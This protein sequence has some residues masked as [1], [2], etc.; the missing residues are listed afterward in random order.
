[1]RVAYATVARRHAIGQTSVMPLGGWGR[2]GGNRGSRNSLPGASECSLLSCRPACL[3]S[4]GWWGK[5]ELS[6]AALF[7]LAHRTRMYTGE[8]DGELARALLKLL[9]ERGKERGERDE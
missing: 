6:F 3:S 8:E 9:H 1:M 4:G 5:N 7:L 2:G